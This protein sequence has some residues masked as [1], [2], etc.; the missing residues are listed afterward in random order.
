MKTIRKHVSIQQNLNGV[1]PFTENINVG[2]KPDEI[3]V[4]SI[5]YY[6]A[7]TEIGNYYV[8]SNLN[9]TQPLGSFSTSR[10]D[11]S[12]IYNS[13]VSCPL[14]V[15]VPQAFNDNSVYDFTVYNVANNA[16]ATLTGS[17]YILLEAV[18][19]VN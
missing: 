5:S 19:Y 6:P 8:V 11:A 18:K 4:R 7:N 2:F 12:A 16:V 3:I 9:Y 1:N 15:I 13:P 14:S 17:I 10:V